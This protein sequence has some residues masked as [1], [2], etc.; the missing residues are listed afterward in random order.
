MAG[1]VAKPA[2]ERRRLRRH[3]AFSLPFP[4]ASPRQPVDSCCL[5]SCSPTHRTRARTVAG[6]G[7]GNF[8]GFNFDLKDQV[9][10]RLLRRRYQLLP[11]DGRFRLAV[12]CRRQAQAAAVGCAAM[13]HDQH[14]CW[15]RAGQ[16]W[17]RHH[18]LAGQPAPASVQQIAQPA[19]LPRSQHPAVCCPRDLRPPLLRAAG[20]LWLLPLRPHQ[21]A[22]PLYLCAGHLVDGGRWARRVGDGGLRAA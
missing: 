21:P 18:A 16:R 7:K 11:V 1:F 15:A 17:S 2:A 5:L 20:V 14:V 9:G 13:L 10:V 3:S 22:D 6:S 12:C 8:L 4:N 19:T